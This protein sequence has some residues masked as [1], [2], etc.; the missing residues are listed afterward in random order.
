MQIYDQSSRQDQTEAGTRDGHKTTQYISRSEKN[1][2]GNNR[3]EYKYKNGYV[4]CRIQ[5]FISISE[6]YSNF[7][8]YW[9]K[10]PVNKHRSGPFGLMSL[11][12]AKERVYRFL[13]SRCAIFDYTALKT[14]LPGAPRWLPS[15]SHQWS[16][17]RFQ[18]SS[19]ELWSAGPTC[20]ELHRC[21]QLFLLKR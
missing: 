15:T 18:V 12:A 17:R 19:A 21:L 6:I 2:N 5:R 20:L 1:R 9:H 11:A 13:N 3:A 4:Q 7:N 16:C 10:N 14:L 8:N